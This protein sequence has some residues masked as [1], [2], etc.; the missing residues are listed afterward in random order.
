MIYLE[1]DPT[2]I[3]DRTVTALEDVSLF[4]ERGDYVAV[5]GPSGSGKT[6][7]MKILGCLDRPS[8]GRELP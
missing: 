2:Y 5:K 3:G 6:T 4:I 8:A 7:L 1:T